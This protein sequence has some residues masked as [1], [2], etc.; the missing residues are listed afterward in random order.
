MC[1]IFFESGKYLEYGEKYEC[2][3][4]QL[5]VHLHLCDQIKGC[6]V[7]S[8]QP[9]EIFYHL[10]SE[11]KKTIICSGLPGYKHRCV[12]RDTL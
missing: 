1:W 9:P 6:P 3:S 11:N 8:W 7:L 2:Q 5:A 4:P 12:Y 10:D